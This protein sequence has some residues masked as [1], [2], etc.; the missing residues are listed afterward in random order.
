MPIIRNDAGEIKLAWRLILVILL[1]VAVSV[2]LRL[3]PI[4]LLTASLVRDG[5]TQ[6]RALE[7]AN[8]IILEDPVWSVVIGIISGLMG[9]LI[10][11][12]LVHVVERSKFTWKEV[13]LD[14]RGNSS[15]FI[16]VGTLLAFLL[17]ITYIFIE[18]LLGS[19]DSSKSTPLMGVSIVIVFRNLI[20]YMGMGFGEEIVFRGYVQTRVVA[21]FGAIW[22][23]LITA[24][25]FVLLHQISYS[26][27]P[28]TI[29]SG[30]MLWITVGALYH[31]SKSL[32]LVGMFHGIMN[33]LLNTL[34]LG[35]TDIGGMAVHA[36][37]LLILI[38]VWRLGP[39]PIGPASGASAPV[40]RRPSRE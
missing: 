6:G 32:Y 21:R 31:L 7:K 15:L 19:F 29:L 38:V 35:V 1:Y 33:T 14:W 27:S 36:L 26:L 3:I 12:F 23:I 16:L 9:L 24:A 40:R 13:G 28:L 20:L 2:L 22:G 18:Y 30:T 39:R 10:V 11:W 4:S 8:T 5:M 17:Y 34:N 25:V 37:A